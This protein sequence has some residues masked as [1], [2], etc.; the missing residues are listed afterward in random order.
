MKCPYNITISQ[1]NQNR[2]EHN[3]NNLNVF[4]EHKL[5]ETRVFTDCLKGD[6]AA[7]RRGRCAYKGD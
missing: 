3:D 7:W 2:Y 6:C 4:H 1:V 5:I